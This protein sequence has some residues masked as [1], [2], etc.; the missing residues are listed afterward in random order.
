MERGDREGGFV[1]FEKGI[2]WFHVNTLFANSPNGVY[3]ILGEKGRIISV[4]ATL[5]PRTVDK[6]LAAD[7][8]NPTDSGRFGMMTAFSNSTA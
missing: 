6:G 3:S 4:A 1:Y 5:H 7:Q 2:C 8:P